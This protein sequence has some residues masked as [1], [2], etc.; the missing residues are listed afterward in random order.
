MNN[1]RVTITDTDNLRYVWYST[2]DT[3]FEALNQL[4]GELIAAQIRVN[5][6]KVTATDT[7]VFAVSQELAQKVGA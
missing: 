6:I 4:M 1:Y 7:D 2:A 3:E 5:S